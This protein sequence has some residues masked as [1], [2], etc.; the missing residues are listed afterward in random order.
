MAW[1]SKSSINYGF[2]P[3]GA[4]TFNSE[5]SPFVFA[6]Y[7]MKHGFQDSFS[8]FV[9]QKKAKREKRQARLTPHKRLWCH[10]S[11]TFKMNFEFLPSE[12]ADF[13]PQI[14]NELRNYN[15]MT[16]ANECF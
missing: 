9:E 8:R 3:M 1:T 4:D 16:F 12:I 14:S 13:F 15:S 11:K 7:C 6:Y 5:M 2:F 10:R